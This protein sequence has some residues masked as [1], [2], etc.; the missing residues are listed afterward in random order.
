MP[1]IEIYVLIE[2]GSQI[3][4]LLT[5]TI[6]L[7]TAIIGFRL[8]RAQGLEKLQKM[9]STLNGE[10]QG[11]TLAMDVA[12]GAAILL[13]GA[14]LLT[15]GFVTDAFGFACL[16]PPIRQA[17]IKLILSTVTIK[18]GQSVNDTTH[19]ESNLGS[20]EDANSRNRNQ[21]P[22][23]IIEGEYKEK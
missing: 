1:I 6:I 23:N 11:Q 20:D 7:A 19:Y 3:G 18:T 15:P 4:T 8:F 5:V 16:I 2:V 12:E 17:M 9:R 21:P 22:H 10:I 13:A 14:L